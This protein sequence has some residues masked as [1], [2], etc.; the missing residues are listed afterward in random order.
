VRIIIGGR[1]TIRDE[2]SD[3][4]IDFLKLADLLT[5]EQM[6]EVRQRMH[7]RTGH[8]PSE[9]IKRFKAVRSAE[10]ERKLMKELPIP[11][12]EDLPPSIMELAMTSATDSTLN[13]LAGGE[14]GATK[15]ATTPAE[16]CSTSYRSNSAANMPTGNPF[17]GK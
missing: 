5:K 3:E 7:Q 12:E 8:N 14:S 15:P 13:T 9:W 16:I 2:S 1:G 17:S 6:E 11:T 4:V 10:E